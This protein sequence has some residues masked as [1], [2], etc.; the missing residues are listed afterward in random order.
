MPASSHVSR[1]SSIAASVAGSV[2]PR[3]IARLKYRRP[4]AAQRRTSAPPTSL[5]PTPAARAKSG[6]AAAYR[7]AHAEASAASIACATRSGTGLVSMVPSSRS[8]RARRR[9]RRPEETRGRIVAA[10]RGLLEE[11]TFHEATVEEVADRAGIARATLYEHFGSRLELVDAMCAT[12]DENPALLELRETV[13]L[14]DAD[15]ALERTL[16]LAVRF[17]SSEDAV[18]AQL[19]GVVAIDPAARDLVERQ[20]ADRRRELGRLIRNLRRGR[21]LRRGTTDQRALAVLLTLTAYE[22]F[23]ELRLAGLADGEIAKLLGETARSLLL[24]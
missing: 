13:E 10:V 23:R 6:G 5:A 20:R 18:L 7:S 17:W 11:G 19:Y 12:F 9:T 4:V 1:V 3:P 21:R 15:A 24:A 2:T 16:E 22:T 8:Y 14:D